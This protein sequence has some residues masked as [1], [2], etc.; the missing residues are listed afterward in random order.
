MVDFDNHSHR[1]TII[2]AHSGFQRRDRGNDVSNFLS[3]ETGLVHYWVRGLV[4]PSDGRPMT[5]V[6]PGS[7]RAY[8]VC[9]PIKDPK[10]SDG[11]RPCVAAPFK[12]DRPSSLTFCRSDQRR[13]SLLRLLV[14]AMASVYEFG[15]QS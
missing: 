3:R 4:N 11:K 13:G 6:V 7:R 15:Q 2:P 8:T 1:R 12:G 14:G 10:V 9:L 5:V